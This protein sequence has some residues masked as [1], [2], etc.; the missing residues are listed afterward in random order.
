MPTHSGL[1][2]STTPPAIVVSSHDLARLEAM[3]ES[4]VHRHNPVAGPLATELYR[5]RIVDPADVPPGTVTMH[6]T[7][8]CQD[9]LS[10]ETHSL[11]LVYP[12]EA[13]VGQGRVSVLAPVGCALLGLTIGQSIDWTGPGGR[14]LRLRVMAV[15][16]T[17]EQAPLA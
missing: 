3:L 7:V 1:P 6:A 12:H 9:E 2:P 8:H 17:P 5:A 10:G 14:P 11:T 16:G 4:P 15:H 13:D